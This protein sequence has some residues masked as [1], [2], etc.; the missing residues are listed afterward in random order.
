MNQVSINLQIGDM[1]FSCPFQYY[2]SE[3]E[4]MYM[5]KMAVPEC[6]VDMY[7]DLKSH[8][9][10]LLQEQHPNVYQLITMANESQT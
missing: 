9:W 10:E 5:T 8:L 1:T 7:M 6:S 3:S 4:K 2:Y